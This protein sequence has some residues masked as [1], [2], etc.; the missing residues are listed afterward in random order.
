MKKRR[1]LEDEGTDANYQEAS[2]TTII[3]NAVLSEYYYICRL[4]FAPSSP[5]KL[6]SWFVKCLSA[7]QAVKVESEEMKVTA[8]RMFWEFS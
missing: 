5:V 6:H 3:L 2:W 8:V 4:E 7:F 1:N